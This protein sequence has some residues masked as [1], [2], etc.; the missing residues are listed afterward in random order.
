[1]Y[2]SYLSNLSH[3]WYLCISIV[4]VLIYCDCVSCVINHLG[5]WILTFWFLSFPIFLIHCIFVHCV[6]YLFIILAL[7]GFFGNTIR[8]I[9]VAI[10]VFDDFAYMF[11]RE[12]LEFKVF[13]KFERKFNLVFKYTFLLL[14]LLW[15]LNFFYWDQNLLLTLEI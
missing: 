11:I 13:G 5:Y 6:C 2:N 1:M 15:I 4:C 14:L 3:W 10:S 9:V 12:I 7:V 8:L